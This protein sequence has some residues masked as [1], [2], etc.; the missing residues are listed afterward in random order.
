MAGLPPLQSPPQ[1]PEALFGQVQTALQHK[2]IQGYV[3]LLSPELKA[4]EQERLKT[5][6]EDFK[7]D[8]VKL[9]LAGKR[10]ESET[11]T[12]L[13][14]QVYFQNAYSAIIEAWQLL[15][16]A[17][18]GRWTITAR[19]VKTNLT[20]L[21]KIKI[22]SERVER[23]RVVEIRHQDIRLSFRDA[24]VFYDNLP[25]I[26]TALVVVGKGTVDFTPSDAKEKH[27]MELLYKRRFLEDDLEYL[28]LRCSNG[29]F[30]SNVKI[31]KGQGLPEVSSFE[32]AKAA[33]VFSRNYSR[34]FTIQNSIDGELLSFLPQGEEAVF[35]FKARKAGELTYIYYPF[36]DE[37]VDLYDRTRDRIISLYSPTDEKDGQ[38][39]KFFI[40]FGEKFEVQ[41]YEL[42]VSYSPAQFYLS[43][44]ARIRVAAKVGTLNSLKFR[45]NPD[46]EIIKICDGDKRELFYTFDKLRKTIYVYLISPLERKEGAWIEVYYRGH[47]SPPVPATDVIAQAPFQQSVR[48]FPRY[49]TYFFTQAGDWYPS[50]PEEDYFLVRL[51]VIVPPEYKCLASGEMVERSRWTEMN[52]VVELEKAGNAIYT[53]ETRRPVKYISFIL[54]KFEKR[55]E[56]KNP[57]PI[58]AF[59]SDQVLNDDPDLF[60]RAKGILDFYTRFFG[61]FPYE[62]LGILL[63]P[64][65]T[66][67]GSSPPS[68]VVLNQA[69]WDSAERFGGRKIDTAVNLS[70]WDDYFLA[71][72]IAHQWWGQGVS[73][74]TYRDQWLSEGLAQF[75]AASYLRDRYGPRDFAMILGKFTHWTNRKSAKGAIAMGS[76]LSFYDFDAYQA[77]IYDK[78][79]LALFML[80]DIVGENAFRAGLQ[81]FFAAHKYTAARTSQFVA[82]MEKASAQDLGEFFDGWFQSYELPDIQTSW[83]EETSP[84]GA[85]LRVH[86]A[87]L[88]GRFHFPLWVEWTSGGKVQRAMAVIRDSN[89][90]AVFNVSGP[91]SHVRINPD[92]EVPGKFS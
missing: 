7:M 84:A 34:S 91:V 59:V 39:K 4:I 67:G 63:R 10:V 11:Q 54:G 36:S 76:R 47:I 48:F 65:S 1:T 80:Q 45:F 77:V 64:W 16:T 87:Q 35:E 24:A 17:H 66:A 8:S 61:P 57:V 88:K 14:L 42:D 78:S 33:G 79:A 20:T 73:V 3:D 2:D 56:W 53:F 70:Q 83:S 68:F 28:Y 90:D 74:L 23:A 30:A 72:E 62:K 18:D 38:G 81:D 92:K 86:V 51:K 5:F 50:P 69:P 49:D 29:F 43:A 60:D 89:Q 26:E 9:R 44:K 31:E 12:R 6:F 37:E 58:Q 25:G 27:Q 13:F 85:R 21:Y 75:A 82:A 22:P 46:L 40:S 52:D 41:N 19:D 55:K 15:L 32:Q 71:H